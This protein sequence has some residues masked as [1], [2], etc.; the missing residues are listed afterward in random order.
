MK[1]PKGYR[2]FHAVSMLFIASLI[3]ANTLAVK[4]IQFSDFT[5][6]AGILC[7]PIAYIVNDCL[8]EVYGFEKTRT[9]IW[10]GF[11]CLALM[12]I[13]YYIATLLT[14]APFW[15]DQEAFERLF[16]V[17]PRIAI[18]SFAAFLIGSFLNS[19]VMS[20]LKVKTKGKYLW[21][22]TIGSTI[23]GEG[24]DS[25]VFNSIAFLGV[26]SFGDVM[27]IALSGFILK[28][29]YEIIM[30]PA[31]YLAVSWLKKKE[32]EDK[33]DVNVKYNPFKL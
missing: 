29:L 2:Y 4:I 7:F 14:P 32:E 19:F 11:F 3:I 13:L 26:F 5:L 16:G 12:S 24:A 30:T 20:F 33:F 8:T 25:L 9:V 28:T 15:K 23:V 1:P 18:G 27:K 21:T 10:W 6:P 17:V 31:T 22:R